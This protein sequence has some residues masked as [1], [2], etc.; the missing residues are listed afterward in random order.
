MAY[1]NVDAPYGLK[2]VQRID[3]LPYAGVFRQLPIASGYATGIGFGDPV[4]TNAGNVE[5][6]D[7]TGVGSA[8]GIFVGCSYTNP[9]TKQPT[10]SQ[11]WPAGMVA[12]DAKAFVVDDP[13]VLFKAAI[14]T[15]GV[16]VTGV[17]ASAVGK[18][19]TARTT[20]SPN[21]A[22]GNSTIGLDSATVA[23]T[24]THGFRIVAVVPESEYQSGGTKYHEV[25][26]KINTHQY[27]NTTGV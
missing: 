23:V 25:L 27:N 12:A 9:T 10:F 22:T 21:T 1:P 19:I 4:R 17:A 14:T 13:N 7:M 18:N 8:I 11:Q 3:G 26:V 2:P 5:V 20:G 16:D 6:S 15:S 24:A